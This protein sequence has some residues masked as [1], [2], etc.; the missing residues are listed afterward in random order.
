[1]IHYMFLNSLHGYLLTFQIFTSIFTQVQLMDVSI[2]FSLSSQFAYFASLK[3][4]IQRDL[5][6]TLGKKGSKAKK[7]QRKAGAII[8]HWP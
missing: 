6:T 8:T 7:E 4:S 3:V 2:V 5:V 1:M